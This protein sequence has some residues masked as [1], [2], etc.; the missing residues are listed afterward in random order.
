MN[1]IDRS[2]FWQ[3]AIP[4]SLT[5]VIA[6]VLIAVLYVYIAVLN[7]LLFGED[8]VLTARPIDILVGVTI[9]LKTSIDFAIFIGRLMATNPGWRGRIAIEVGTALG[10]AAGTML[11]IALW[12][13]FKDIELL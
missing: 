1:F 9:Y 7:F 6:A 11:V 12:V 3:Q 2:K 5:G 13:M 10:N 8:V 4:L